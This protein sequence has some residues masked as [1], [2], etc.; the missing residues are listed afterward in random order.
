MESRHLLVLGK[1]EKRPDPPPAT[2]KPSAVRNNDD[3]SPL[4]LTGRKQL[5]CWFKEDT[6]SNER[7]HLFCSCLFFSFFFGE[8]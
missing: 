7:V 1:R 2:G 8:I 6:W 5:K 3:L 4:E